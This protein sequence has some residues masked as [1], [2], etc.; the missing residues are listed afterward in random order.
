MFP[1][2]LDLRGKRVLV[3]GGGPVG[4]RKAAAAAAAGATVRVVALE[5]RPADLDPSIAWHAAPYRAEHLDGVS[6]AFAAGP[7]AVT[8]AVAADA[9]ARGVWVNAAADPSAGDVHLPAAVRHGDFVVSVGTGGASPAF[10]R[11]VREK[12]AAEYDE[13]FGAFVAVLAEV[14]RQVLAEVPD[15]ARRRDLLDGFADWAWLE[16]LRREGPEV[17]RA[18]MRAAVDAYMAEAGG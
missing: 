6:L 5:P 15:A 3:V 14:R 1:V 12:L 18:A 8:A 2:L 17:V 9:K 13:S 7:P 11:R 16:R 10:A 4:R